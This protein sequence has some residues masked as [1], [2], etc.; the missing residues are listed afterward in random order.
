MTKLQKHVGA[1]VVMHISAMEPINSSLVRIIGPILD[2]NF[3]SRS[4][5]SEMPVLAKP[6]D[7][8]LIGDKVKLVYFTTKEELGAYRDRKSMG[9]TDNGLRYFKW[10]D[11]GWDLVYDE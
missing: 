7:N 2:S 4:K 6:F 11:D 9:F 8:V 1:W 10:T 3:L 5:C